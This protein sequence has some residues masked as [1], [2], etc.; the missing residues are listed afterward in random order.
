[1]LMKK[2]N[3]LNLKNDY[4]VKGLSSR[5][6]A[7]I[8]GCSSR[9]ILNKLEKFGIPRRTYKENK[10]PTRKGGIF[11]LNIEKISVSL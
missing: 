2:L 5:E 4:L 6:L 10:M 11:L 3:R 1:M 7:P 8:Y 9:T